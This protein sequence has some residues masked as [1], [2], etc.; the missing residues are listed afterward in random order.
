M[1]E[2]LIAFII[3]EWIGLLLILPFLI[4]FRGSNK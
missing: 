1:I 3:G 4:I 2:H